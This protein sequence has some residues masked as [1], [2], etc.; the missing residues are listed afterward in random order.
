MYN[1]ELINIPSLIFRAHQ[2]SLGSAVHSHGFKSNSIQ[3]IDDFENLNPGITFSEALP[4]LP[5]IISGPY[6]SW[7]NPSKCVIISCVSWALELS[8]AKK[9]QLKNNCRR[10]GLEGGASS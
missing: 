2:L 4:F 9:Y 1:I 8:F 10:W 3:A 6:L 5:L 7:H